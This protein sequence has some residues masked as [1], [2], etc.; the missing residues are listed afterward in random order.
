MSNNIHQNSS[1]SAALTTYERRLSLVEFL[2]GQPGLRVAD[3]SQAMG[4]SQGTV[5]ND[6]NALEATGQVTRVHGGAILNEARQAPPPVFNVRQEFNSS[7]KASIGRAAARLIENGDS[8]YLDSS[9]T[10]YFLAQSLHDHNQLRVVTNG[11]DVARLLGQNHSHLVIVIGGVLSA[12][13]SSLTGLLSE[14]IITDLHIQKAFVSCSGFSLERGLTEVFLEEAQLKRKTIESAG[15][16]YAL[17]DSSKIGKDDLTV[18]ARPKQVSRLL[19]D[20]QLSP[21]WAGR[22]TEAGIQFTICRD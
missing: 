21:E 15:Q 22:L 17:V 1:R 14:Q 6:L 7:A 10:S 9:S 16:V 4:V 18:F 5:R 12:D 19:T 20:D 3:L 11:I 8:I 13:G 2:R